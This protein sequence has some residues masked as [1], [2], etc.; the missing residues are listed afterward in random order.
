MNINAL[1]VVA[2]VYL[3]VSLCV[4]CLFLIF[5]RFSKQ[6]VKDVS[7]HTENDENTLDTKLYVTCLCTKSNKT[8]IY[9]NFVVNDFS[10]DHP[11]EGELSQL[12]SNVLIAN[13]EYDDCVILFFEK[14][15]G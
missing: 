4:L 13:P 9:R 12:R 15:T 6:I 5:V 2:A 3:V 1:S 10:K 8:K 14:I 11:S 7:K